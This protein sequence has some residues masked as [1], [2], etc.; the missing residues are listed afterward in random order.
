MKFRP[1]ALCALTAMLVLGG[2][3]RTGDLEVEGGVGVTAVRSACPIAAVPAGTGDITLFNPAGSTDSRAIDVTAIITNVRAECGQ[4][5]N[6]IV[7]RLTFDVQG[8]RQNADGARDVTLPYFVSVV[9]GG[10]QVV[11]KRVGSVTLRF[12]PGEARTT[13]KGD[14][15]A[16]IDAAAAT[17]PDEVRAELTRRRRAGDQDAAIDPLSTPAVRQAVLSATFEAL[18]GFQLTEAQLRYNVTR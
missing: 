11:S 17:L 9:R 12:A 2:C 5:G 18:V 6:E 3:R 7:S 10:T 14:G 15:T 4:T 16:V 8:S 13:A 1:I